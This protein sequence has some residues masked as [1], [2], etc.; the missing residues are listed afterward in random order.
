[1]AVAHPKDIWRNLERCLV[2]ILSWIKNVGLLNKPSAEEKY[3]AG[4]YGSFQFVVLGFIALALAPLLHRYGAAEPNTVLISIGTILFGLAM[5]L[6]PWRS[7]DYRVNVVFSVGGFATL[8]LYNLWIGQAYFLLPPYYLML[9]LYVGLMEDPRFV[10]V[11]MAAALISTVPLFSDS[12]LRKWIG[13]GV[14]GNVTGLIVA[15]TLI[16]LRAKQASSMRLSSWLIRSL[17]QVGK[18]GGSKTTMDYVCERINTLLTP[19]GVVALAKGGAQNEEGQL[20]A[21][22][23]LTQQAKV[24][25]EGALL[26]RTESHAFVEAS[27]SQVTQFI[28]DARVS[29]FDLGAAGEIGYVS[30]LYVPFSGPSKLVGTVGIYWK[31]AVREPNFEVIS[32]VEI[33]CQEAARVIATRFENEDLSMKLNSDDLTKLYNRRSFFQSI[34]T[35]AVGDSLVFLDLDHFK[36]LNDTLGHQEGD[37]ELLEFGLHLREMV[38]EVDIPCRYGGEEF[39]IILRSCPE[40][41][42]QA[43]IE[44]LRSTWAEI[45]RVTFS[46]GIATMSDDIAPAGTLLCADR[47]MYLAK[48]KGRNTTVVGAPDSVNQMGNN[49]IDIGFRNAI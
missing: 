46:A 3:R 47:A 37:K 4:R 49:V 45:G 32:A 11:N 25:V 21:M 16:F 30:A 22:S 14:L 39:A 1:M 42:A 18:M 43:F 38:R 6:L 24:L 33:F 19:C 26:R 34:E 13:I 28:P 31:F 40:L 44:R 36:T 20:I 15:L 27:R 29:E 12:D 41:E 5:S 2:D 48:A 9:F 17:S 10:S 7:I 8:A 35:L 23:F